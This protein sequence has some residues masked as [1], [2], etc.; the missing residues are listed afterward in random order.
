[1]FLDRL[2]SIVAPA[3]DLRPVVGP[4]GLLSVVVTGITNRAAAVTA[5][6]IYCALPGRNVDGHDFAA[7]ALSNG[8]AAA[9]VE[10]P[11]PVAG[12]Q[13][14]CRDARVAMAVLADA[15][16]ASPSRQLKVVGITGTN[17]K[18]TTASFLA[19]ILS[20]AGM[21]VETIGTLG[22]STIGE[23]AGGFKS[24]G[25]ATTPE[26][27]DLQAMLAEKL[28]SGVGAVALE[29]SSHALV[30]HRVDATWFEVAVFTN[31]GRDHLDFHPSMDAY[32]EAKSMLFEPTRSRIGVVNSDD[33]WGRRLLET[34]RIETRPFSL[35]DAARLAHVDTASGFEWHGV[36]VRLAMAGTANVYN[37]LAAATAAEALDVDADAVAAGIEAVRRVPGR[38]EL[39]GSR[40]PFKVMIDYAHT[41]DALE[42]VLHTA[43]DMAD[44]HRILVVFGCGGERDRLKRP[45]MGEVATRLSDV[46]VLTSDNPR[47]ED[48]GAITDEI[49]RGMNSLQGLVE[50]ADRRAAI[51][52][53]VNLAAPGDVV[54]VA[55]KG[56][57]S[58]Q[59]FEVD[60][61]AFDD[62]QVAREILEHLGW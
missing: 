30:S 48:P 27:C 19:S 31:L 35:A 50:E 38:F 40:A 29:V 17:G 59:I 45:L 26:S 62:R 2:L 21:V 12:L 44:G 43:R 14:V 4:E 11:L 33:P 60:T 7:A 28:R 46:V 8:A 37:A 51:G 25:P 47:S 56:H 22:P 36:R 32:F 57:E 54:V 39:V 20:A 34:A 55:G 9:L 16:Y 58:G 42:A 18:T 15:L 5:G 53:A 24:T 10:R 41:P 49:K 13:L 23:T 52:L 3:V 61:V 1:M 6:S